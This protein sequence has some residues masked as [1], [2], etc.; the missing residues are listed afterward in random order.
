LFE[1]ALRRVLTWSAFVIKG[2]HSFVRGIANMPDLFDCEHVKFIA[3]LKDGRTYSWTR[4]VPSREVDRRLGVT[5]DKREPYLPAAEFARQE[6]K[7]YTDQGIRIQRGEE[8]E[9]LLPPEEIADLF[10]EL[11]RR[12]LTLAEVQLRKVYTNEPPN[13]RVKPPKSEA[14]GE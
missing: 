9:V 3:K 5:R 7:A 10:T 11:G 1:F 13:L 4:R 12:Q 8:K 6:A 14:G 2:P